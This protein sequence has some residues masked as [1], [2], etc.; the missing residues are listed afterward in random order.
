MTKALCYKL[1]I[2][3]YFLG[4]ALCAQADTAPYG[5]ILDFNSEKVFIE[6]KSVTKIESFSC[7]ISSLS[8]EKTDTPAFDEE[9]AERVRDIDKETFFERVSR[10]GSF[11]TTS[12]NNNFAAYYSPAT[13]GNSRT[14]SFF[15]YN[16]T[17]GK[18]I[19]KTGNVQYWDLLSEHPQLFAFS[20]DEKKL[21]YIDDREGPATLYIANIPQS[22]AGLVSK[23]LFTRNYSIATFAFFDSD[24]IYFTANRDDSQI[25]SL[26][27]YT[28]STKSIEKIAHDVS[29][30]RGVYRIGSYIA[31]VKMNPS[32]VD[33]ELYNPSTREYKKFNI[34]KSS[35]VEAD[36]RFY[37]TGKFGRAR[38]VLMKP[39]NYSD[40]N[41]LLI[42]LHGG[43]YRNTGFT[44]HGYQ[45][46]S[47]YDFMLE[48]LR[49]SNVTV[50][51]L[52][53]AGSF[54]QGRPFAE[55]IKLGVGKRDVADVKGAT[56]A[57]LKGKNFQNIYVAGN[58][59]GGYTALRSLVAYPK[60]FDGAV[61]INGVT[62]WKILL[63]RLGTS[64]FNTHFNGAPN[65]KNA[66]LYA[67]ASITSRISRL[68]PENKVLLIGGEADMTISPSQSRDL[69]QLL[70]SEGKNST[71]VTYPGEDHIFT[72]KESIS[73]MCKRVITF[74]GANPR[75]LCDM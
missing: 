27:K 68:T 71:L 48:N 21:V 16:R 31:Y 24:T 14:R 47:G 46:Y 57:I 54:G 45:S 37:S 23:R 12:A 3:A 29:W 39:E 32:S 38:G 49:R 51:K 62:D 7:S 34:A 42:W 26:Y 40:S 73:D 64:I 28:F 63:A 56:D 20:P 19:K 4:A 61:S 55:S 35:S 75:N 36:A 10:W 67:N 33:P 59:F 58:S 11:A 17:T 52:D 13:N 70:I 6:Y 2:A 9:E 5:R 66:N 50:L 44:H 60:T 18:T 22:G 1:F 69:N 43:P 65:T 72:K 53:Y 25:W 30:A 15:L 74:A 41:T 8:C